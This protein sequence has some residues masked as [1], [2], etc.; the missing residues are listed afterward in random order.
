M[1]LSTRMLVVCQLQ[2][3]KSSFDCLGW[4][5]LSLLLCMLLV[6]FEVMGRLVSRLIMACTCCCPLTTTCLAALMVH[7]V[8][9]TE[10]SL[11]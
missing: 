2:E 4:M 10:P 7:D 3:R 5:R 1:A 11:T 6:C 8:C 9:R